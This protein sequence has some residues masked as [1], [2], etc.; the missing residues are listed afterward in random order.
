VCLA[1]TAL[2]VI[3]VAPFH[4]LAWIGIVVAPVAGVIVYRRVGRLFSPD[5]VKVALLAAPLL[6][7]TSAKMVSEWDEFSHWVPTMRFLAEAHGFPWADT[8]STGASF[9]AYPYNWPLLGYLASRLAGGYVENAGGVLNTLLLLTFALVVIRLVLLG[10]GQEKS[11]D[12][13][14]GLCAAAVLASTLFNPAFAQKVALTA[15]ADASTAVAMGF[16]TVLGWLMLDAMARNN[17]IRARSLAWQFG[18]VMLV[19][20]NIKQA[21][22]VLMVMLVGGIG[23]AGLRDPAIRPGDLARM[24]PPMV[25]PALLIYGLWRYH[26]ATELPG[27]EA[28]LL[29]FADWNISVIPQILLQ[30]LVVAGKKGVYFAIMALAVGFAVKGLVRFGGAFDRLAIIVGGVF[31]GYNA[32]LFFIFVA[33]F[34]EF[35]ALRVASYWRYNMHLGLVS[36]AFG[37]Y[38]LAVLWKRTLGGRPIHR[39]VM[40][41]PVIIVLIAP[42]AFAKKVRFDLEGLKPHYQMVGRQLAEF[43]APGSQV[44]IFDPRGTGESGVMTKYHLGPRRDELRGYLAAFHDGGADALRRAIASL[45]GLTHLLVHSQTAAVREVLDIDLPAGAS[46]LLEKAG[47]EG[48]RIV[49]SW[50]YPNKPGGS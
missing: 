13:G 34:G 9:P 24:L 8:S 17:P 40:W 32:F 30:M 48:W 10:A 1:F 7:L 45:D 2:G 4:A 18:L 16:G 47:P 39:A 26:V 35:D 20:V 38:G 43:V 46:H 27:T 29:P 37:A 19:L 15:Y 11:E 5:V 42:L 49:R 22:P 50:P 12:R 36:V 28:A 33:Q 44:F 31:L 6:L 41:L 25:L 23:L 3:F 21:N 14:W